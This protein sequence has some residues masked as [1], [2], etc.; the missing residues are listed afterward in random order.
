MNMMRNSFWSVNNEI[1]M[2]LD[3]WANEEIKIWIDG[4]TLKYKAEQGKI[5]NEK[6][7][8]LRNNKASILTYLRERKSMLAKSFELTTIQKAYLMGRDKFYELGGISANYYFE[9]EIDML[10]VEKMEQIFNLVISKNEAMRIVVMNCGRQAVLEKVPWYH[11]ES[12]RVKNEEEQIK[13]RLE[14]QSKMYQLESWPMFLIKLTTKDGFRFRIHIGFDCIILDAWSVMLMMK[15]ICELYEKGNTK[16]P[17]YTFREYCIE[18]G[19]LRDT[20]REREA[21]LYWNNRLFSIPNAPQLKY[22]RKLLDINTPSFSRI[23]HEVSCTDT[24]LIYMQAKKYKVTPAAVLC[25]I[26]MKILAK[27]ADN[28][29]FTINLTVFNRLSENREIQ[30]VLGDFTNVSIAEYEAGKRRTFK[31]EV[32]ATQKEFWNFV[33]Y[34]GYEGVKIIRK[35]PKEYAAQA[36][37]PVVFTGILVGS[38]HYGCYLSE[39]TKE[40]YAYSQTP[41]VSL[42][43][44]ATDIKGNL[45]INWDYCIQAFDKTTICEMFNKNIELLNKVIYSSWEQ[46]VEI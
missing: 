41:Q 33:K 10:D 3:E 44:Q 7:H 1:R 5:N 31:E 38:K 30:E 12:Y 8:W 24:E 46:E 17:A 43:Y 4:S 19:K 16:F 39:W 32:H 45:S 28:K 14:W 11:I 2:K 22:T 37:L 35:I 26:Y 9:T 36:A 18:Q 23:N 34:R 40:K 15:Q 42:D 20:K 13:Y 29:K 27:Y 6:I 25:S 21:E